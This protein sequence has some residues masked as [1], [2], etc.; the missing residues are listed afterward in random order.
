MVDLSACP[1]R[2]SVHYAIKRQD[3][4]REHPRRNPYQGPSGCHEPETVCAM[5][6]D[7]SKKNEKRARA[8]RVW[9][10]CLRPMA[11]VRWRRRWWWWKTRHPELEHG[12]KPLANWVHSVTILHGGHSTSPWNSHVLSP[13]SPQVLLRLAFLASPGLRVRSE[14]RRSLRDTLPIPLPFQRPA[15]SF[16]PH[17]WKSRYTWI[18]VFCSC[19]QCPLWLALPTAKQNLP[20]MPSR[21]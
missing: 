13:A 16:S 12:D 2:C 19:T 6:A 7:V 20:P 1:L 9:I 8:H 4:N 3:A 5:S 11:R 21:F 14:P 17:L 10:C 18:Y 15:E